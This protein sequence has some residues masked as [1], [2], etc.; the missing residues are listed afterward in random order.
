MNNTLQWIW[1]NSELL[2][3][4]A[5][6]ALVSFAVFIAN[7][8]S[9]KRKIVA[10]KFH[11]AESIP[12]KAPG[13]PI[14]F[15]TNKSASLYRTKDN[16]YLMLH[17]L[18]TNKGNKALVIRAIGALMGNEKGDMIYKTFSA[19]ATH[20][21]RKSSYAFGSSEN[22]LPLSMAGNTSRDAYL[23]FEFS[24]ADMGIG[25]LAFEVSS[26]G[27]AGIVALQA[28]VVG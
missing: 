9:V 20:L 18:I 26:S 6:I 15:E 3:L 8:I 13:I 23:C 12:A 28:D 25:D 11:G 4:C 5:G 1:A 22:L 2:L 14:L 24:N 27:G 16:A 21:G 17:V 19:K 10:R 7:G